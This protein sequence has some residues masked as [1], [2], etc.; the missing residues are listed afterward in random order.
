MHA[1]SLRRCAYTEFRLRGRSGFQ[2]RCAAVKA[3]EPVRVRKSECAVA[4]RIH[5][6][7]GV[8]EYLLV[9][10]KLARHQRYVIRARHMVRHV[11]AKPGRI[12]KAARLHAELLRPLVHADD[13]RLHAARHALRKSYRRIV[14]GGDNNALQKVLALHLLARLEIDL[15]AAH[16]RGVFAH[17]HFIL[18]RKLPRVYRLHDEKQRHYLRNRRR[19]QGF[20]CVFCIEH[21]SGRR[22]HKKCRQRVHVKRRFI[23]SGSCRRRCG[24][25]KKHRYHAQKKRYAFQ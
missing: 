21:L 12:F 20:G 5:P 16:R 1:V 23:L 15:R 14:R 7:R 2:S 24:Q 3:D 9:L 19:R 22:I 6:Y 18:E 8:F 11:I 17:L 13:K 4:Y 25:R 10:Q